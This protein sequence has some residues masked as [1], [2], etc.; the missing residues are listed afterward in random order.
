MLGLTELNNIGKV[1]FTNENT[2]LEKR[3]NYNLYG[4]V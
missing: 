2:G 3:V 4:F 1:R